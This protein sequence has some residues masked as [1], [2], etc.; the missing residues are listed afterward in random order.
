VCKAA[1]LTVSTQP[2][3]N[4]SPVDFAEK[5]PTNSAAAVTKFL[6]LPPPQIDI[7]T[8]RGFGGTS[9]VHMGLEEALH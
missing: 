7:D 2:L 9:P 3:S 8:C 5:V 6:L 4:Q 1:A